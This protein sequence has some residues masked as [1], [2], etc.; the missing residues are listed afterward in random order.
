[1]SKPSKRWIIPA[2]IAV[3][4]L[5]IIAGAFFVITRY[6]IVN[7]YV[8]GNVHYTEEEIKNMVMKGRFDDNSLILSMK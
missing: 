3:L 6:R 8:D 5:I 1:M 7:V 4:L 2:I